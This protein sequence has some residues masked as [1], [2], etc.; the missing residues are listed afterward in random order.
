MRR[1]LQF[2][3]VLVLVL[4]LAWI[5][6]WWYAEGRI[7]AGFRQEEANLRQ[8]GWTVRHGQTVRGTSPLIARFTV[9]DL[10]LTPPAHG[11]PPVT[12][13]VPHAS[14][15]VHAADPATLAIDLPTRWTAALAGGPSFTLRFDRISGRLGF[16]PGTA[17]GGGGDPLR[18]WRIEASGVRLD[19]ANTNFTLA[20]ADSAA[21]SVRRDPAAGAQA[22]ALALRAHLG[23]FA[24]SPIFVTLGD[25]P[26]DGKLK[27]FDLALDVSGPPIA[28]P[29]DTLDIPLGPLSG[30]EGAAILARSWAT[31]A[32]LLRPWA[33]AGGHGRYRLH[34]ALGPLDAHAAG[35]FGFDSR[36]QPKAR[37][38]VT[39]DGIS[40]FLGDL[41]N[42]YPALLAPVSH[43]TASL[44]PYLVKG[45]QGGQRLAA[46]LALAGGT[47]SANGRAVA[48]VPPLVWPQS[49]SSKLGSGKQGSGSAAG[50]Q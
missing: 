40:G 30:D 48:S 28:V 2:V 3:L 25:L 21:A 5:G 12:I 42:D 34:L 29:S 45:P 41:G 15:S 22:T 44:A 1:F 46:K 49:P 24:L 10:R 8:Q 27:D 6:L 43:L 23:G 36:L 13:T 31:L 47:V 37:A 11:G 16:D 19:S 20:S 17:L 7:N 4:A 14:F 39:A 9:A 38:D 18:S 33:E 50:A 35:T 32:P 26:F